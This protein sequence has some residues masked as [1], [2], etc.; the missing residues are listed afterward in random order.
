MSIHPTTFARID[1]AALVHNY[2]KIRCDAGTDVLCIVKADAYGHGAVPCARALSEAGAAFFGVANVSEAIALRK[3]LGTRPASILVL[4]YTSPADVSFLIEN[5]I[6]QTVYSPDYA[7]ALLARIP[8]G[9]R[10]KVHYKLD[11]GMNRLGFSI[12]PQNLEAT[13]EAVCALCKNEKLQSEGIFTHFACADE[14]E[15]PMTAAQWETFS[16]ALSMLKERSIV[17]PQVHACNSAGIY[18]IPAARQSLVRAGIILYG[19]APAATVPTDGLKPVM[20]LHTHVTHIHSVPCGQTV[21]YGAAYRAERDMEIA[22]LA[23]GYADG[24]IRAYN[25]CSIRIRG[26]ERPLVGRICMDQC[27]IDVTGM[28]LLPGEEATLFDAEHPVS[29]LSEKAGMIPYETLCLIGKRVPRIYG[30]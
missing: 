21:G 9:C 7:E 6:T 26:E 30:K 1:L 11:S 5:D 24:F 13:V 18:Q 10:L 16:L 15:N 23:I 2:H 27:M 4:G 8:Q 29:A 25:G 20:S 19:V 28:H 22:T 12:D 17:L 3:G 14:A